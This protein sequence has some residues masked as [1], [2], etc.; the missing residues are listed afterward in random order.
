MKKF[1]ALSSL[2]ITSIVIPSTHADVTFSSDLTA[3]SSYVF[4]GIELSE[5]TLHPSLEVAVDDFYIGIWAATPMEKRDSMGYVDEV[6]FYAGYGV[7]LSSSTALD[8]GATI[9][10]YP[11]TDFDHT[12]EA[13][14][15][16]N[17]E[18]KGIGTGLYA[19]YDF[20][21]EVITL[22]GSLGWSIPLETMGTSLDMGLSLGL[23]EPDAGS[24]YVY[25]GASAAVP[26][27]VSEHV[28]ITSSI[29]WASHNL[30]GVED[31]HFFFALSFGFSE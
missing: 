17:S 28:T 25:Y 2:L 19:F 3:A 23:V 24:N 7:E 9:Y 27:Q 14:I 18:I 10:E 6:D 20:D 26:F 1:I 11:S 31:N 12:F 8:F 30:S 16:I 4:R 21:L 22:V 29:N 13:F 15:G 5:L